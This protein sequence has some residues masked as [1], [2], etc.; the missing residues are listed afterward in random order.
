MRYN[1][2][3]LSATIF[4]GRNKHLQKPVTLRETHMTVE[5]RV[6][7]RRQKNSFQWDVQCK[8]IAALLARHITN[9]EPNMF[10]K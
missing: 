7:D 6:A 1:M 4:I 10:S 8:V 5:K 2:I 9:P 3:Q